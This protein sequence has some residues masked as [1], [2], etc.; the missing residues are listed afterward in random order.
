MYHSVVY[1]YVLVAGPGT[2]LCDNMSYLFMFLSVATSNFV[3]TALAGKVCF[4][5]PH[6]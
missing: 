3:A 2:V 4:L 6:A 1:V 5:L